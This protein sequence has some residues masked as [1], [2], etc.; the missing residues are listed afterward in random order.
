[1]PLNLS[2]SEISLVTEFILETF[3]RYRYIDQ[4]SFFISLWACQCFRHLIFL[5]L[6]VDRINSFGHLQIYLFIYVGKFCNCFGVFANVRVQHA[7]FISPAA[8]WSPVTLAAARRQNRSQGHY[9]KCNGIFY[10]D[11]DWST[12]SSSG[13]FKA[14]E[15]DIE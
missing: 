1:M 13:L 6:T 9:N 10:W 7:H 15:H 12:K 2:Y 8:V 4:L 14:D 3:S 11:F 5:N